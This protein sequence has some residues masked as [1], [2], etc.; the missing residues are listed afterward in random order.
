MKAQVE[1]FGVSEAEEAID[2]LAALGITYPVTIN[3][4]EDPGCTH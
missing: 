4:Y 3:L 2:D 1:E